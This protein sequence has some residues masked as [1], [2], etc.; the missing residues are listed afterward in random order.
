MHLQPYNSMLMV[1]PHHI[2]N[3]KSGV[4]RGQVTNIGPYQLP[5][6]IIKLIC[7]KVRFQPYKPCEYAFYTKYLNWIIS[8]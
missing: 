3:K 4:G 5:S 6:K 7:S 8:N 1:C 2:L